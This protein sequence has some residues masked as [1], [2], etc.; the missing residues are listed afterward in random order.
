MDRGMSAL[1]DLMMRCRAKT[2]RQRPLAEVLKNYHFGAL[3]KII[4]KNRKQNI[5]GTLTTYPCREMYGLSAIQSSVPSNPD[6]GTLKG[7]PL[8]LSVSRTR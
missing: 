6:G 7:H 5:F 1:Q 8:F 3:R 2:D 4:L